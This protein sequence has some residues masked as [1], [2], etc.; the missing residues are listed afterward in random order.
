MKTKIAPN[1]SAQALTMTV[2]RWMKASAKD[3]FQAWTAG[4]DTWFAQPGELIMTAKVD[5]PFFFYNRTD[6]GRHP[7]Y[8]RFLELKEYELVEMA[9]VTGE[10]GTADCS[11]G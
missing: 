6:W 5:Q 3:L 11:F 2:E 4:M 7:H 8:G 10:N 1:S 9:W